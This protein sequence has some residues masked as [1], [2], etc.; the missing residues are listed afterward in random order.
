MARC[1]FKV[2]DT[3]LITGRG[4]VLVPGIVPIGEERFRAGDPLLLKRPDG[5]E[6]T[7]TIGGLEMLCPNPR[8]DVII[9]LKGFTKEDVPIGTEIWSTEN[10]QR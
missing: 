3:F 8:R 2:E 4:L 1:L 6:L 10:G 5:S 9:M 7:T